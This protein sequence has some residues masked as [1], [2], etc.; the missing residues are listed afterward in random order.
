MFDYHYGIEGE[1]YA[2]YRIPKILMSDPHFAMVSMDAKLL[3][4]LMLDRLDL[5]AKNGWRDIDGR[6]FIYFTLEDI[7]EKLGCGKDK[8]MKLLKELE[9]DVGLIERKNKGREDLR[10]FM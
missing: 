1:Q 6:I 9:N 3:Y 2:F 8:A 4:G 7:C 5:S 10:K